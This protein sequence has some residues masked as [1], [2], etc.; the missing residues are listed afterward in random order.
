MRRLLAYVICLALLL[1]LRPSWAQQP[2]AP[3][4]RAWLVGCDRFVTYPSTGS[5]AQNNVQ[6]L[7]RV[8]RG[9]ARAYARVKTSVNQAMDANAFA[10]AASEAYRGARAEDIALFYISSHGVYQAGG[11]ASS[12][13]ILLSDGT[14]E[15]VL[16]AADLYAALAPI[17]G[18][19]F[20]IIDTCNSGALIGKGLDVA[21]ISTYFADGAFRVLTS[22]GGS[23]PSFLWSTPQGVL[24]GGSYFADAMAAG[25]LEAGGFAADRNRNG[26]ITLDELHRYLLDAY[27]ASTPQVYPQN[28]DFAV[29]TYTPRPLRG[30][31][32]LAVSGV[33]CD[34]PVLSQDSPEFHFSYTLR[35]PARMAYQLVYEQDGHWRFDAA[36]TIADFEG[37]SAIL[38]P[39]RKEKILTLEQMAA[40][41][42]GYALLL[43]ATVEE[44]RATPYSSILLRVIPQTG[45]PALRVEARPAPPRQRGETQ[46]WVGHAFACQLTVQIKDAQG[47]TVATLCSDSPTRPQHLARGGSMFYW[48]GRTLQGQAAAPGAYFAY[49]RAVIGGQRFEA[50]SAAFDLVR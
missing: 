50:L 35:Q 13:G 41:A 39:G 22:A 19:K 48:D 27:G 25:L 33:S 42:S 40:D 6:N 46:V 1:P 11:A 47:Q 31:G 30:Q 3:A 16:G 28:N 49:A 44:D 15:Y 23:E 9:E 18:T 37:E 7:L 4:L 21:D 8:L 45:D 12:F 24:R 34:V 10:R 32:L 20:L 29:L 38:P 14:Q 26:V 17:P 43:I 36:Q 5:A 2:P